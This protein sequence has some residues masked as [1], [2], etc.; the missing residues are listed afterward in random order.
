MRHIDLE[1][2]RPDAV[3]LNE[4]QQAATELDGKTNDAER[5]EYLK[6]RAGIWRKL[7]QPLMT[8][9]GNRCWF[10]DAEELVS[11]LDIDHFRPKSEAKDENGVKREGYWWLAF[12]FM[13]YRLVGQ[14]FNRQHKIAYF[15]VKTGAFCSSSSDRRWKEEVPLFI[16]PIRLADV[17]LVA[18]NESGEMCYSTVALTD[19]DRRRVVLTNQLLGLSIHPPLVE[20]RSQVWR[21]CRELLSQ[22][23]RTVSEER[24][25]GETARTRS[26]K[27]SLMKQV[28]KMT[29]QSQPLS[30]VAR[31]CLRM[32][33][34][35]WAELL[36]SD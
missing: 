12:D 20:A 26:E 3:W 4:A 13:N 27:D 23:E 10:T 28:C 1:H 9:F 31:S 7:R 5:T 24:T 25:H 17:L 30:S 14:V 32:S 8:K 22:I 21:N 6:Q 29:S 15:P 18:Y 16:D 2:F 11:N 35:T 34:S 33:G 36:I 19:E